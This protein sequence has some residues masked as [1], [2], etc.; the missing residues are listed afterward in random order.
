M[1]FNLK[2]SPQNIWFNEIFLYK[3]TNLFLKNDIFVRAIP[4]KFQLL[5]NTLAYISANTHNSIPMK[6]Q[7]LKPD[8]NVVDLRM[9]QTFLLPA[10]M[11]IEGSGNASDGDNPP[12]DSRE[13]P[14]DFQMNDIWSDFW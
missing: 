3:I 7:Y 1:W 4:Y 11:P 2:N 6:R 9:Q 8:L 12:M 13:H 14:F 10:S 5:E